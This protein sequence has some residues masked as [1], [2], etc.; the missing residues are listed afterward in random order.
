VDAARTCF[1]CRAGAE[2]LTRTRMGLGERLAWQLVLLLRDREGDGF[3]LSRDHTG[4]SGGMPTLGRP[5]T[6][7]EWKE[8]WRTDVRRL[9]QLDLVP[10]PRDGFWGV[11]PSLREASLP[12]GS[13]VLARS[14]HCADDG[15]GE[16]HQL[17]VALPTPLSRG[18]MK[19]LLES[20]PCPVGKAACDMGSAVLFDTPPSWLQSDEDLCFESL[21]SWS[22]TSLCWGTLDTLAS[23]PEVLG[24]SRGAAEEKHGDSP[25]LADG[26]EPVDVAELR[27]KVKDGLSLAGS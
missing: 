1:F 26:Q 6:L 7:E 16:L 22:K 9:W 3:A 13:V 5:T 17:L 21:R 24:L 11:S 8:R 20:C 18:D 10:C 25:C 2:T 15:C 14:P 19:C 27:A 12:P 23:L 4:G